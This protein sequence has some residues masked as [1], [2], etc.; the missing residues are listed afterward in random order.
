[1]TTLAYG[2]E[3]TAN[4]SKECQKI[5]KLAVEDGKEDQPEFVPKSSVICKS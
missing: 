1:M 2:H 5:V 3:R 4:Q